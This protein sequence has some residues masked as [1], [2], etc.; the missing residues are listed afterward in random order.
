MT[1]HLNF[2]GLIRKM[3]EDLVR[4][5][6]S[7]PDRRNQADISLA[8]LLAGLIMQGRQSEAIQLA[9]EL[10]HRLQQ[11]DRLVPI[12][13]IFADVIIRLDDADNIAHEDLRQLR[14][15]NVSAG[16]L[17]L[18][19]GKLA[20]TYNFFEYAYQLDRITGEHDVGIAQTLIRLA[21]RSNT[22]S[23]SEQYGDMQ[24]SSY[25]SRVPTRT[26]T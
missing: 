8:S 12:A 24:Y 13:G 20:S 2:Y 23:K 5:I 9:A 26:I 10:C 25:G 4:I 3:A 17:L 14:L 6:M 7:L 19:S 16:E 22:V 1:E 21:D 15:V 11:S 18:E